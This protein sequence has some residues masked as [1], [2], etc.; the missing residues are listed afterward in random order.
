M[1][2]GDVKVRQKLGQEGL[3]HWCRQ[4]KGIVK[5]IPSCYLLWEP[6][7][8]DLWKWTPSEV[9]K[10]GWATES[11]GRLK[12]GGVRGGGEAEK[13]LGAPPPESK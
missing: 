2:S 6:S 4:P 8:W 13:G 7:C 3:E 10:L 11:P 5:L 9:P 12:G 1:K